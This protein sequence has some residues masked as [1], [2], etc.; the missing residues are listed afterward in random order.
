MANIIH[1]GT[2]EAVLATRKTILERA[3]HDVI[4][5][6]DLREVISACEKSSFDVGII[7]Q[8]LPQMEKLRVTDTLRRVCSGIRILEFHDAIKPDVETAD[9]H[10]RV[11]DT[12]PANFLD[13]V[14]E[15][16]RV[17]R[18]KGKASN[19]EIVPAIRNARTK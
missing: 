16:A 4:L 13:T 6:R 14:T 1:V 19:S 2:N 15:L 18:K 9:A 3:G 11:A 5:A 7:G 12:T 17:R 8:A 10:L